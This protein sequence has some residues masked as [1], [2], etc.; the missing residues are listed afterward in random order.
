MDRVE[1]GETAAKIV[2]CALFVQ[3]LD[4]DGF[5]AA[6]SRADTVGPIVDPSLWM[7]GHR[8]MNLME[9]LASGLRAFQVVAR[10]VDGELEA[11]RP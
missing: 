2:W 11:L 6:I 3:D 1:Y 8:Q 5:L 7:E 10:E 4:L 9:R